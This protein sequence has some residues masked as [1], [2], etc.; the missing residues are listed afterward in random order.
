MNNKLLLVALLFVFTFSLAAEAGDEAKD[1]NGVKVHQTRS[2][3]QGWL[4]V[5]IQDVTPKLARDKDLKLKEG[6]YVGEVVEE[7]PADS[8]G[9]K[10]GDVITEFNGKKIELAEDLTANVQETKPGT[11]VTVKLNR[12]GENKS[13]S[14]SLGK[15]RMR[16]PFALSAPHAP[17][18]IMNLFGGNIEGMELMELNKQLAEYFEAPSNKAV[19][20]KEVQKDENAAKAGI[21]AGDILTKIGTETIKAVDD[22]HDAISDL[23]EGEKVTIELL[24]KGKKTTVTLEISEKEYGDNSFW[25]EHAP[26]GFNFHIQPQM[27]KLHKELEM[28]MKE[29]PRKHK[30]IQRI[31][32]RMRSSE[33]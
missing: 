28:K 33:V 13:L 26:G 10:E 7:S 32:S 19:L 5:S 3:K 25:R 1:K 12:N 2:K 17:R 14:V 23:E 9:I 27:D 11:K 4:G 24:R 6:A 31:E 22:V 15:N 8:A 16:M 18:V 20:V 21:K 30:E 29:L